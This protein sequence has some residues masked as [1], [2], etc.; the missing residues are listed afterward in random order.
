VAKS[1]NG[2]SISQAKGVLSKVDSGFNSNTVVS[3]TD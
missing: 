3:F 2:L 1:P